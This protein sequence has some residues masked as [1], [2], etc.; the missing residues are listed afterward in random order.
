MAKDHDE[1]SLFDIEPAPKPQGPVE[2][3]GMTFENDEKRREYFLDKLREKLKDPEFRKIEGFPIGED[4]DIL[5]LSDPPYYTACPNPFIEDFIRYNA[6]SRSSM[7]EYKCEPLAR[8]L[9]EQRH[10]PIG[11]AHSY[12]TKISH[13]TIEELIRHYT[14]PSDIVL[15]SFCGSGMTGVGTGLAN[16]KDVSIEDNTRICIQFDLSPAATRLAHAYCLQYQPEVFS[17]A[18]NSL[19]QQLRDELGWM[20]SY[21][22]EGSHLRLP[23]AVWCEIYECESCSSE[24]VP[25]DYDGQSAAKVFSCNGCGKT[26]KNLGSSQEFV[27]SK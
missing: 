15:D 25:W 23:S 8:E 18:A 26:Y 14:K 16:S 9:P 12:H 3:L 21:K 4:E 7:S 11:L 1:Q 2:C 5:A 17:E 13:K 27:G 19:L 6:G 20:Y 22:Y 10:D 24:I